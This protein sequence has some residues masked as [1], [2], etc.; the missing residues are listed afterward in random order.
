MISFKSDDVVMSLDEAFR[1]H[2]ALWDAREKLI[3]E[4]EAG[5]GEYHGGRHIHTVMT[6]LDEAI[7]SFEKRA[8]I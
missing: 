4:R 7:A 1:I 3:A 2:K 6:Q 8:A 5:T